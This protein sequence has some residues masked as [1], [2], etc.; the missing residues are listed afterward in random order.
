MI[1]RKKIIVLINILKAPFDHSHTY[2]KYDPMTN[3][4]VN[5]TRIGTE[6]LL[7]EN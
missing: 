7:F 1:D 5:Q 3:P 4:I 2:I 6:V